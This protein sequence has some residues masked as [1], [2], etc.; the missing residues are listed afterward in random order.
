MEAIGGACKAHSS[1][2]KICLQCGGSLG[3]FPGW[4]DP[5][6]KGMATYSSV[7]ILIG[8]LVKYSPAVQVDLS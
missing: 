5:L 7:G 3:R 1:A 2:G 8:S 6:E 4:K